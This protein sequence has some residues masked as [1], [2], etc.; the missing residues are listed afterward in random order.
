MEKKYTKSYKY[1]WLLPLL[2]FC[3]VAYLVK[4][5]Q[6][7]AFDS[8]VYAVLVDMMQPWLTSA[9]QGITLLG[10]GFAVIG[11]AIIVLFV[12][13]KYGMAL[14]FTLVTAFVM[15][16]IIKLLFARPRPE[17][18]RL[19][20]ASGFSFPSSHAMISCCFYGMCMYFILQ[21]HWK[22]KKV[23]VVVLG[24]IILLIGVSRIYLGVHFASDVI[25]GFL[26]SS[27]YLLWL[28]N[29]SFFKTYIV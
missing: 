21:S 4:T 22:W 20:E 18:L 8:W 25:A 6:T 3:V 23:L 9:F 28:V 1:A 5:Q 17:I 15:N 11:I 12:Q 24:C 29:N 19:S 27:S 2:L 10:S 7:K 13:R 14:S 16:N 26:L